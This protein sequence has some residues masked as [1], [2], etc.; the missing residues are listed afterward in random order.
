MGCQSVSTD[1]LLGLFQNLLTDIHISLAFYKSQWAVK[2]FPQKTKL[3]W[4]IAK[5]FSQTDIKVWAF[6]KTNG[7]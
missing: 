1:R 4:T 5:A 3:F 6:T 7:L 2:A